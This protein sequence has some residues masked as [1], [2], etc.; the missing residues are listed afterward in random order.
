MSISVCVLGGQKQPRNKEEK[1][2]KHLLLVFI[3]YLI[4]GLNYAKNDGVGRG[5]FLSNLPLLFS[6]LKRI[7]RYVNGFS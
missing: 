2:E 7:Y 6:I 5:L 3:L 1:E 4:R